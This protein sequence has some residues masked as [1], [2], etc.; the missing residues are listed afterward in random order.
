[1][2]LGRR[3]VLA[4]MF[5]LICFNVLVRLPR[6]DHESGVDSFA[7]HLFATAITD[8]GK[9]P[10]ILNPLG[11]F[12]WYPLSYPSAAPVLISGV[13]QLA[14]LPEEGAILTL[15]LV[16]GVIGALGGF[17]MARAF[18]RDDVFA[19]IVAATFS[20]APRFVS[21]TLWSG[22]SRNL[23]MV[24]IPFFIWSLVQTYRKSSPPNV[25]I[26]VLS[27]TFM[28]GTHRLT[29]LLAVVVIAFIVAYVFVLLHRVARI[30]FPK[31]LLSTRI[32]R[33]TPRIA[34]IGIAG[35]AV[36]MM[37]GTQ[38]LSEYT[39]GEICLGQSL[40][41]ELCN[42]GISITRSVGLALPFALLGVFALVRERN[43]GL[44]ESFLVF[45]LLALIPTLFL[46]QYTGFYI[47][48]FLALF[49]AFG[50][51]GLLDMLAKHRR[52]RNA[53]AVACVLGISAFSVAIVQ[54]EV[55][56]GTVVSEAN[57]T[58]ALYL[59][60]LP[61]GNFVANDGLTTIRIAAVSGRGGLPVGGAGT[62]AQSPE[63]LIM[64]AYSPSEIKGRERRFLLQELTI[65]DDSPFWLDNLDVLSDWQHKLLWLDVDSN[66]THEMRDRYSLQ[67]YLELNEIRGEY[68]AFGNVYSG[69][70]FSNF[71]LS[72][73]AK[74]YRVY[75]GTTE[76]LY[77]VFPP[78]GS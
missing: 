18:R 35:I 19:L 15:D 33:W 28:L 29:I 67:Y 39:T 21:F 36:V 27:L 59:Q 22:S 63:I 24:M 48:P 7:I 25:A 57:Y 69:S 49:A 8:Q 55:E 78:T 56:R 32:R 76:D 65:E 77:L 53:I 71:A 31:V 6:T 20:L 62:T 3:T 46:R 2:R 34:L 40:E 14:S 5:A 64:G 66:A 26:L 51:V 42:L 68:Q 9:I 44:A 54:V 50:I 72:V 30:R 37:A 1:M 45:A 12:G 16:Y 4:L 74:R 52:A 11:Y 70:P 58:T 13:G 60:S 41:A 75:A 61:Q 43:K 38:V 73:H 47:L 23:F 17:V 10:W